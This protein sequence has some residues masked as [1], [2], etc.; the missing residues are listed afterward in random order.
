MCF[1]PFFFQGSNESHTRD[2]EV[3][4]VSVQADH[5]TSADNRGVIVNDVEAAVSERRPSS[6]ATSGI[7]L[8]I[9][10]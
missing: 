2:V 5:Y 8:F 9:S 10:E 1:S 6:D 3:A 4:E 7:Q